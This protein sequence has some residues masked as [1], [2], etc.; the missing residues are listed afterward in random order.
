[1]VP[2]VR[3]QEREGWREGIEKEAPVHVGLVETGICDAIGVEA[4]DIGVVTN[5]FLFEGLQNKSRKS[6][7]K[8]L[9]KIIKNIIQNG[10][11]MDRILMIVDNIE[12]S[13]ESYWEDNPKESLINRI[14]NWKIQH[15][16]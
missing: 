10:I 14:S 9:A 4:L 12:L 7:P 16:G 13:N 11:D 6:L 1:M 3:V 5:V 8:Y 15:R 2:C